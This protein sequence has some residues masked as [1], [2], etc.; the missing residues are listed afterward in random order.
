MSLNADLKISHMQK[1]IIIQYIKTS[2]KINK[3][4]NIFLQAV[5][6][7]DSSVGSYSN[8]IIYTFTLYKVYK[9]IHFNTATVVLL[10]MKSLRT[11]NPLNSFST[12]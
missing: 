6:S 1:N 7:E 12:W 9:Y 4:K 8:K 10:L 5:L 2:T 11:A 3:N